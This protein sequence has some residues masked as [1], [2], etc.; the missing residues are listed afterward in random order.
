MIKVIIGIV[1]AVIGILGLIGT[2]SN[3]QDKGSWEAGQII[4]L[5]IFVMLIVGGGVL[6]LF[7]RN[8]GKGVGNDQTKAEKSHSKAMQNGD[9]QAEQDEVCKNQS[10]E[11]LTEETLNKAE[12]TPEK[13]QKSNYKQ[14]FLQISKILWNIL[15]TLSLAVAF[16]LLSIVKIFF[17]DQSSSKA[18]AKPK[19]ISV[20]SNPKPRN[21]LSKICIMCGRSERT[22]THDFIICDTCGKTLCG[23]CFNNS[24]FCT[25]HKPWGKWK[26]GHEISPGVIKYR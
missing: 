19:P 2:I 26:H 15:K 16:V 25:D 17:S 3:Y 18:N 11:K 9:D 21:K 22:G 23:R 14:S 4:G 10:S 20:K 7:G 8:K 1:I 6:F 24:S 5:V 13:I 12:G